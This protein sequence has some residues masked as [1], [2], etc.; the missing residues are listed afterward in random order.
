MKAV[1]N[2]FPAEYQIRDVVH[3]DEKKAVHKYFDL[4]YK[5]ESVKEVKLES[6]PSLGWCAAQGSISEGD[7]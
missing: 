6:K 2:H 7:D 3:E 4:L 1:R 5:S